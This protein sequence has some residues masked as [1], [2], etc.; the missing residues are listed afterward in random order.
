VVGVLQELLWH[1]LVWM[2]SES[3]SLGVGFAL[4]WRSMVVMVLLCIHG[5][6]LLKKL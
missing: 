4:V 3:S 2:L 6:W 5:W 1:L